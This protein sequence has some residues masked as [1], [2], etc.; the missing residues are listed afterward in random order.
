MYHLYGLQVVMNL[1]LSHG[2][3]V[4]TLPRFDLDQFLSSLD[5]YKVTVAPIV[6]PIV[7]A[8]S[9]AGRGGQL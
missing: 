5:R 4:V 8:L 6:P 1:A 7:S 2:A 9:R 3:T